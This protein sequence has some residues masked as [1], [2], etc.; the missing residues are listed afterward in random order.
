MESPL[1]V[2]SSLQIDTKAFIW[3][4][5]LVELTLMPF[6]TQ[7]ITMKLLPGNICEKTKDANRG[8]QN[9]L[10]PEL[11]CFPCLHSN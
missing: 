3:I 11:K 1:S 4:K 9:A 6:V 7:Y 8:E 10:A 2:S 5:V